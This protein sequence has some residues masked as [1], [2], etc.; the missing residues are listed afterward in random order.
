MN[1]NKEA[2]IVI[3]MALVGILAVSALGGLALMLMWNWIMPHLFELPTL[4]YWQSFA[5]SLSIYV[6]FKCITK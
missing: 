4:T 2:I 3:V 5:L 6:L 1:E